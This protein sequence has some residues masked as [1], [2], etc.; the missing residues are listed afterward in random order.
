LRTYA[1]IEPIVD[2]GGVL[3]T[4]PLAYTDTYPRQTF[5]DWA[6]EIKEFK[7]YFGIQYIGLGT[8]GGGGLPDY[9]EGWNDITDLNLLKEAMLAEGFEKREIAAFMGDN[10]LRVLHR[11]FVVSRVLKKREQA[12]GI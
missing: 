3:C 7:N 6:Q 5:E 4:W 10:L 12:E 11:C 1:E 2:T 8:D 9:I